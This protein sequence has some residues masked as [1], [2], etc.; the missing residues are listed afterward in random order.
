EVG[1]WFPIIRDNFQ[2]RWRTTPFVTEFF[3]GENESALQLAESQVIRYNVSMVATNQWHN[4][5]QRIEIG[6]AAGHR[7]QLHNATWPDSV[8]AGYAFTIN[9]TWSNIGVAPAYENWAPTWELYSSN[10]TRVWAARSRLDLQRFLPTTVNPDDDV[11]TTDTNNPIVI[12][13]TLAVPANLTAGNYSLRLRIPF[14]LSNGSEHPYLLPLA[15]A[16]RGRDSQGRYTLGNLS[17]TTPSTPAPALTLSGPSVL[18][19]GISANFT[20]NVTS[21]STISQ[22]QLL[23]DGNV[24]GTDTTSPYTFS[25]T[26]NATVGVVTFVARATDS[27]N[28]TGAS[29][30][31]SYEVRLAPNNAPNVTLT[32]TPASGP[33][34]SPVNITLTANAT[35]PDGDSISRVEFYRGTTLLANDTSPPYSTNTTLTAGTYTLLARA[36]DSRGK[37]GSA[38]QDITVQNPPKQPYGGT[39]RNILSI[40]QLED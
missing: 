31:L 38:T 35:D 34:I 7:F 13:D 15:I 25:W 12:S 6:K 28:R 17:I 8:Q 26:P 19:S 18:Y 2:N 21:N 1:D 30:P 39:P 10:G 16:I 3:G 37:F 24:V 36:Y 40:I 20:A 29:Q 4:S 14:I 11:N 23:A 22:V 33:Y 5:P 27:E 9:S 32:I